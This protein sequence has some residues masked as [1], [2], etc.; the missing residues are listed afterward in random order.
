MNICQKCGSPTKNARVCD[1]CKYVTHLE[2]SRRQYAKRKRRKGIKAA[3]NKQLNAQIDRDLI[4]GHL[5]S[6]TRALFDVGQSGPVRV[7]QGAEFEELSRRYSK[8]RPLLQER[9]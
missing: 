4:A 7:I 6:F 1:P 5:N 2:A 8:P 3:A 9:V